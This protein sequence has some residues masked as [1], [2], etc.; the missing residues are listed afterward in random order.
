MSWKT[1]ALLI[2]LLPFAGCAQE[3]TQVSQAPE[4]P[5]PFCRV[6]GE[7]GGGPSRTL[8]S[9]T[10]IDRNDYKGL[11]VTCHHCTVGGGPY[12]VKFLNGEEY[13]AVLIDTTAQNDMSALVI[14][15][16]TVEQVRCGPFT[17]EGTYRA[18]GFGG[19]GQ[20]SCVEGQVMQTYGVIGS[21]D[22][23]FIGINGKPISGDSGSGTVNDHGEF[24]G[25]LWGA[26]STQG[27]I[28]MGAPVTDF[29]NGLCEAGKWDPSDTFT[30]GGSPVGVSRSVDRAVA[31]TNEYVDTRT[32]V[33]SDGTRVDVQLCGYEECVKNIL[34]CGPSG[35]PGC[36]G[37]C[38][39]CPPHGGGDGEG[40]GRSPIR[41]PI[42]IAP[43]ATV[44]V[45]PGVDVAGE[46]LGLV[47]GACLIGCVAGFA[48]Y[49]HS[50][51]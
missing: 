34:G 3:E 29:L 43:N 32:V 38:R 22:H 4:Y 50:K 7:N 40:H 37:G 25:V 51:S 19:N 9:G 14:Q 17:G 46:A 33:A 31:S 21:T 24:C 6:I 13:T 30:P 35:C 49:M 1:F 36:G 26:S 45:G 20:F 48:G 12:R 10:L 11:V 41:N 8:C 28:T 44:N 2:A 5:V 16:P 27:L 18:Y 42:D 15:R 39:I 47:C 23:S